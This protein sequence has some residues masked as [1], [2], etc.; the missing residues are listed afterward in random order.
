MSIPTDRFADVH[1]TDPPL[2]CAALAAARR[3]HAVLPLWPRSKRPAFTDWENAATT[4]PQKI[5]ELWTAAPFNIGIACGPSRL[6]VIDLDGAKGQRPPPRWAG[7]RNGGDVLARVAREAGRPFPSETY[8]VATPSGLHLYFQAP[9]HPVL[10]S[11]VGR[12]GWRIDTRGEGGFVVAPGSMRAA[13]SY[14]VL[15]SGP[16]APLPQWLHKA[17]TP[18]ALVETTST[19]VEPGR[20]ERYVA[21]ALTAECQAVATAAVGARHTTLLHAAISLG[22]LVGADALD[23]DDVRSALRNAAAKHDADF[24]ASEVHRTIEDGLAYGVRRPRALL[25]RAARDSATAH[26]RGA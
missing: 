17:L 18:P 9:R 12:L 5:R 3:G 1:D 21:A 4:D 6:L 13:G 8:T 15:C 25:P 20:M 26:I 2:L 7:A 10:R 11:S 16:I 14:R 22:T 23:I 19:S 24:P